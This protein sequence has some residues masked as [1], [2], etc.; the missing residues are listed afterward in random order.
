ETGERKATQVAE[1]LRKEIEKS[2]IAIDDDIITITASLGI[3][4][5]HHNN[6]SSLEELLNC[7]DEALYE[8][9]EAGRNRVVIWQHVA[10]DDE[11]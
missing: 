7:A 8:A 9:K 6:S 3:A 5:D 2:E 4:S 11:T 1:R 10:E